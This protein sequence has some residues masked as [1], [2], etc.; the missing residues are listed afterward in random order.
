M[1][2]VILALSAALAQVLTNI[3]NLLLLLALLA[4]LGAT[5]AI[6]A[7]VSAQV[8]V[9]AAA[10]ATGAGAQSVIGTHVGYLGLVP[11]GMGVWELMRQ[12]RERGKHVEQGFAEGLGGSLPAAQA[13]FLGLSMDSFTM[14][15]ALLADTAP[16]LRPAALAG[17]VLAVGLMGA[18]ALGF[19]RKLY[20]FGDL[21]AWLERLGPWVMILAGLYVLSDTGTDLL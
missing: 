20:R 6:T 14:F 18:G 5:R 17:A 21:A 9:L 1:E 19:S 2:Q 8:I 10:T 15:A 13:M 16:A 4:H 12:F 3:D 7:Y 11:L